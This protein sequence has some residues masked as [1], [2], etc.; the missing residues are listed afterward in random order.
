MGFSGD[1]GLATS[2]Q[3]AFPVAVYVDGSGNIFI[4]DGNNCIREV[5]AGTNIIQTVAGNTLNG[6]DVENIPATMAPLTPTSVYGDSLGNIYVPDPINN[7]IRA[8]TVGGNIHTVVGN[9][10]QGFAGDGGAPAN[11]E[12]DSPTAVFVSPSGQILVTDTFNYRIR[13]VGPAPNGNATSTTINASP[14]ASVGGQAVTFTAAIASSSGG[15]PTGTVNFLD[16]GTQIGAAALADGQATF[17]TSSLAVGSHT[18]SA[19]YAGNSTFA[20]STSTSLTGTMNAAALGLTSRMPQRSSTSSK[21]S[22]YPDDVFRSC[23]FRTS[24]WACSG[25]LEFRCVS[26]RFLIPLHQTSAERNR[27]CRSSQTTAASS[28]SMQA[29]ADTWTGLVSSFGLAGLF[30]G[31]DQLFVSL[32]RRFRAAGFSNGGCSRSCLQL[33]S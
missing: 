31:I 1:G 28:L 33:E 13:V 25:F 12:L 29:S 11:A 22:H 6:F 19:Q 8:F 20:S 16:N 4:A 3:L 23:F 24:P 14:N 27:G 9:R 7:S 5:S 32:R 2:A 10:V 18:I 30:V 26:F 17:I 15:T 21:A